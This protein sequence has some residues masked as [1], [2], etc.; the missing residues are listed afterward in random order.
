[1]SFFAGGGWRNA[2]SAVAQAT[3]T[4]DTVSASR[5]GSGEDSTPG[6]TTARK[7]LL[8]SQTDPLL[9]LASQNSSQTS[10]AKANPDSTARRLNFRSVARAFLWANPAAIATAAASDEAQKDVVSSSPPQTIETIIDLSPKTPVRR[11]TV[12]QEV[13]SPP[14]ESISTEHSESPVSDETSE[15]VD[16]SA[17]RQVNGRCVF[18]DMPD[19]IND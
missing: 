4:T 3:T 14:A 15:S 12:A 13:F 7:P 2:T 6:E 16:S 1:M 8:R 9:Q 11:S 18:C 19:D 5:P 10:L 17:P